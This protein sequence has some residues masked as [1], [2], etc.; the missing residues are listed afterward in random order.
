MGNKYIKKGERSLSR[1]HKS[2]LK[3]KSPEHEFLLQ[4]PLFFDRKLKEV[5]NNLEI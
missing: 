4:C 2:I 1:T 3:K 5:L